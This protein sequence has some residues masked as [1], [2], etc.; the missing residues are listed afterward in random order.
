[1]SKVLRG[2]EH[3]ESVL[4]RDV[5]AALREQ[6]SISVA[7]CSVDHTGRRHRLRDFG[8]A[9]STACL[10]ST[11]TVA[12]YRREEFAVLLPGASEDGACVV[13]E[14]VHTLLAA[15]EIPGF[16][17]GIAT[18]TPGGKASAKGLLQLA[19]HALRSARRAG[20]NGVA[21]PAPEVELAEAA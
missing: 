5:A 9:L 10:R 13:L 17:S 3:V 7:L 4:E 12:R 1:M 19:G 14:R 11:D 6:V 8:A 21:L 16:A 18:F 20:G 2:R 15:A